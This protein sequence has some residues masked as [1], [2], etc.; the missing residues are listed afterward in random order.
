MAGTL[1]GKRAGGEWKSPMNVTLGVL[2]IQDS[3]LERQ[4]MH[5]QGKKLRI[6]EH[7]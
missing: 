3:N 7:G 5:L 4:R 6:E 2:A 1:F